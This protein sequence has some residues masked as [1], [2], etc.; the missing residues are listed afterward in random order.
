M[1]DLDQPLDRPLDQLSL[2]ELRD[3]RERLRAEH[4]NEV[5]RLWDKLSDGG[6]P[7][8]GSEAI[9]TEAAPLQAQAQARE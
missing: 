2:P 8:P 1:P 9:G 4:Q 3:Y 5:A 6:P 7:Q